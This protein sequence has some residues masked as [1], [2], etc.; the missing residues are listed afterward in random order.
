MF[1]WMFLHCGNLLLSFSSWGQT[2]RGKCGDILEEC[3]CRTTCASLLT[4]CADYQQSCLQVSPYS[5]SML[6]GRAL[7][8][9]NLVLQPHGRVVCRCVSTCMLVMFVN[10][11]A[12]DY[13]VTSLCCRF[14]GELIRDGFID[15]EGHAHCVSPLLY[16]TGW[17]P[18]EVSTDGTSFDRSG[19]Y[20]SSKWLECEIKGPVKCIDSWSVTR[21]DLKCRFSSIMLFSTRFSKLT[22][23]VKVI[24]TVVFPLFST[25]LLN[26]CLF[27]CFLLTASPPQ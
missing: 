27:L 9:L 14:K 5:S 26:K 10:R 25:I 18:F 21:N 2:C 4:C 13:Q 7:R 19:E 11:L 22:H 3:S 24:I 20:L 17:I 8:I 6:G 1:L 12:I 23:F 16:E 15:A